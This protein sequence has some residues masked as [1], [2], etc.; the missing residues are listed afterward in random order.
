MRN[1]D[2]KNAFDWGPLPHKHIKDSTIT[3]DG[4]AAAFARVRGGRQDPL[5]PASYFSMRA[6]RPT[7]PA[8]ARR[9]VGSGGE[10]RQAAPRLYEPSLVPN[11]STRVD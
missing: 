3:I 1:D 6:E 5:G 8:T 10:R 4:N 11:R 9:A 2:I 7:Q